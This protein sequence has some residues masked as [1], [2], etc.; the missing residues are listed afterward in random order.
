[1]TNLREIYFR[2]TGLESKEA[3]TDRRQ[4][5]ALDRAYQLRTF[6]IEYYW[7]RAT[8][9]W[10]FQIAIF[11]AFG[12]A[13]AELN[14]H[15]RAVISTALGGLGV[16]VSLAGSL[17]ARGS[18]FWQENWEKH[19]DML[20]DLM[21]GR[22]HKTVWLSDGRVGY[23]VSRINRQLMDSLFVFWLFVTGYLG[24]SIFVA[25]ISRY[26]GSRELALFY[27]AF[28]AAATVVGIVLL[29]GHTSRL[30]GKLFDLDNPKGSA[31]PQRCRWR[32]RICEGQQP[33]FILRDALDDTN[34]PN[35]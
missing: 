33:R 24:S 6:E 22:L 4:S 25:Q 35:D 16:L 8:Y 14:G 18:K 17:S 21:E 2:T 34:S 20:E 5:A 1:M 31:V 19:I 9:F 7:K 13:L 27:V 30:R 26:L 28:I 32:R 11:A 12:L 29:M 15:D 23:S 10:G 3:D